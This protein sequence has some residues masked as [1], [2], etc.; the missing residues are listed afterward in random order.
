MMSDYNTITLKFGKGVRA[1][2]GVRPDEVTISVIGD[3]L[4]IAQALAAGDF[5]VSI[6]RTVREELVVSRGG[7]NE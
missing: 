5:E 2:Y 4:P 7:P 6:V 3:P 1:H